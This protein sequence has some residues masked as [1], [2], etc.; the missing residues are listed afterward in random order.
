VDR[1]RTDEDGD[2]GN[3]RGGLGWKGGGG[4]GGGDRA[5]DGRAR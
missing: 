5:M 2:A 3:G 1:W 4:W